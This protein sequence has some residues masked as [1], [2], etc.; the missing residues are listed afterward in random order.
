MDDNKLPVYLDCN[1]EELERYIE[2][3]KKLKDEASATFDNKGSEALGLIDWKLRDG[4][5]NT[6]FNDIENIDLLINRLQ[7]TISNTLEKVKSQDEKSRESLREFVNKALS[8]TKPIDRSKYPHLTE[9]EIEEMYSLFLRNDIAFNN[10]NFSSLLEKLANEGR[11]KSIVELTKLGLS[12]SST[13]WLLNYSSLSAGFRLGTEE[14]R[15]E[16]LDLLDD[17]VTIHVRVS[18]DF[19]FFLYKNSFEDVNRMLLDNSQHDENTLLSIYGGMTSRKYGWSN[20]INNESLVTLKFGDFEKEV[21]VSD[22][23]NYC[24]ANDFDYYKFFKKTIFN[25]DVSNDTNV[26]FNLNGIDVNANVSKLREAMSLLG[27]D[28]ESNSSGVMLR[29][30]GSEKPYDSANTKLLDFTKALIDTGVFSSEEMLRDRDINIL[31]KYAYISLQNL[32]ECYTDGVFDVNKLLESGEL[33]ESAYVYFN[34]YA[35]RELSS[36]DLNIVA[37]SDAYNF[38]K[39]HGSV[40]QA[41]IT[42]LIR[43]GYVSYYEELIKFASSKY[44]MSEDDVFVIMNSIDGYQGVGACSYADTCNIIYE[45]YGFDEDK[46]Q[47]D[48]GYPILNEYGRINGNQLLLDLYIH[49]N[50]GNSG[51][52]TL[53]INNNGK[54]EINKNLLDGSGYVDSHNQ[55]YYGYGGSSYEG[56]DTLN[57]FLSSNGNHELDNYTI[58]TLNQDDIPRHYQDI[59]DAIN[60]KDAMSIDLFYNWDMY[61]IDSTTSSHHTSG[62]AVTPVAVTEQGVLVM[63]WGE[64]YYIPLENV[65]VCNIFEKKSNPNNEGGVILIYAGSSE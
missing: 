21:S 14:D 41:G 47:K 24:S 42:D 25:D 26:F 32:S 51:D 7:I 45:L 15:K 52:Q 44:G 55:K 11:N 22:L 28:E 38:F 29:V 16:I 40:N 1:Y 6:P 64:V 59:V 2:E 31:G 13:A 5:D 46:F 58:K 12:L 17:D 53:L 9:K 33:S 60:N 49:T 62:H 27:Q 50:I 35:H 20:M 3:L 65:S 43:G 39:E 63:S 36:S 54:I 34:N 19:T 10:Y 48:F 37:G 4:L 61:A 23:Y 18:N 56:L 8:Y 57:D 30:V